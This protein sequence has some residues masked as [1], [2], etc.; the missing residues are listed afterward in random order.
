MFAREAHASRDKP[1]SEN[2]TLGM[3]PGHWRRTIQV[4]EVAGYQRSPQDQHGLKSHAGETERAGSR[5]IGVKLEL[6]LARRNTIARNRGHRAADGGPA[7]A[8]SHLNACAECNRCAASWAILGVATGVTAADG[9][10]QPVVHK[11]GCSDYLPYPLARSIAATEAA[12]SCGTSELTGPL[13]RSGWARPEMNQIVKSRD[14]KLKHR[15]QSALRRD[16]AIPGCGV[17]QQ[18]DFM[19][20]VGRFPCGDLYSSETLHGPTTQFTIN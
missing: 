19:T 3:P 7:E 15:R 16:A 11:S 10:V 8:S 4:P 5:L 12:I 2:A 17:H 9:R 14:S 18:P 6:K 20:A 13:I 1:R